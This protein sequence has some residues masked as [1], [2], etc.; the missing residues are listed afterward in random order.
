MMTVNPVYNYSIERE[1]EYDK[2]TYK[3]TPVSFHMAKPLCFYTAVP[4]FMAMM[5][6]RPSYTPSPIATGGIL[7]LIWMVAL[8][9][10]IVMLINF[11]RKPG[12]IRISKA[13][14]VVGNRTFDFNHISS[15]LIKDPAGKYVTVSTLVVMHGSPHSLAG[16]V[17]SVT[18]GLAQLGG[19]SRLAIRRMMQEVSYKVCIRYGSKDVSIATGL[20][21]T[22]AEVLFDKLTEMT[23]YR[24]S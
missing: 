24:K 14:L 17:S 7:W 15:I 22:D 3:K 8:S 13:N 10:G 19:E 4:A 1:G 11:F 18:G 9:L 12:E 5:V 16:A 2:V 21:E 6:T 20:G 23:G